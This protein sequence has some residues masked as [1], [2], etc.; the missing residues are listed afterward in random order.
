VCRADE[1]MRADCGAGTDLTQVSGVAF[2]CGAPTLTKG[3][4]IHWPATEA[5]GAQIVERR[6]QGDLTDPRRTR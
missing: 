5:F 6:S 1:S 4:V 3:I 2:G